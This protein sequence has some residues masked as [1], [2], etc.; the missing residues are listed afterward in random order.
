MWTHPG[1]KLLFM[2]GEFGQLQEWHHERT[3]DWHLWARPLHAGVARWVC[4]LNAAYR[5]LPALHH[6]DFDAEGF[7]WLPVETDEP[8]TVLAFVRRGAPGDAMAVAIV[9]MTPQ[10]RHA[11]RVGMPRAGDW[12][13]L[14]N[15]DATC[16]GG[17]GMGNLGR[18]HAAD[19]PLAGQPASATLTL[20]PLATLVLVDQDIDPPTSGGDHP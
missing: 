12:H 10:P 16:Y 9:N 8:Q 7:G 19:A 3:L 13:E 11:L 1:K 14:L 20:P 15:S 6:H 18:V 4:D 17:S 2:G 5:R